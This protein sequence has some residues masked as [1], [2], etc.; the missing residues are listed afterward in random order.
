MVQKS[1]QNLLNPKTDERS[2]QI[3]KINGTSCTGGES[4][5]DRLNGE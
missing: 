5:V 3:S 2:E 1:M 4:I